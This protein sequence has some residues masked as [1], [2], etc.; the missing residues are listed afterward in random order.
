MHYMQLHQICTKNLNPIGENRLPCYVY[1]I[2]HPAWYAHATATEFVSVDFFEGDVFIMVA[3][4]WALPTKKIIE[5]CKN[6][7]S[8]A[9]FSFFGS[10]LTGNLHQGSDIDL[11]V[12]FVPGHIP[13]LFTLISMEEELTNL[14]GRKTD[15]RTPEELSRYF[16]DDV[17]AHARS[18]YVKS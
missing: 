8:I 1:D 13:S 17:I 14:V 16:R 6:H 2:K 9:K 4:G 3:P 11:L 10:A 15:L 5:Y 7:P 18:L 12:E